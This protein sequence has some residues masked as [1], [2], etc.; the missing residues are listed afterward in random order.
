[1]NYGSI[2]SNDIA[3]ST[4]LGEYDNAYKII[5]SYE[6]YLYMLR[7]RIKGSVG[8]RFWVLIEWKNIERKHLLSNGYIFRTSNI[9]AWCYFSK[10]SLCMK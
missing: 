6:F 2:K 3:T 10:N 1:M 9:F 8:F 7:L 4:S 5:L